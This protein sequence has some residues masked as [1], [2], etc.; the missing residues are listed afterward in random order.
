MGSAH[1]TTRANQGD[2]QRPSALRAP[3]P[4][5][6]HAS[7]ALGGVVSRGSGVVSGIDFIYVF[8]ALGSHCWQSLTHPSTFRLIVSALCGKGCV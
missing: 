8:I 4:A 7:K 1:N 6:Y 3:D 2:H 5:N